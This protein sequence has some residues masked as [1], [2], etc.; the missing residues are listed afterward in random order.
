MSLIISITEEIYSS[1]DGKHSLLI[2][3]EVSN[4]V[5]RTDDIFEESIGG[6]QLFPEKEVKAIVLSGDSNQSM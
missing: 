2:D 4:D 1:P 6:K 3:L 5:L